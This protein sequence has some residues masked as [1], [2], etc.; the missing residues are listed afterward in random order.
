MALLFQLLFK[1]KRISFRTAKSATKISDKSITPKWLFPDIRKGRAQSYR[2][3]HYPNRGP[4]FLAFVL[5]WT[6]RNAVSGKVQ[7]QSAGKYDAYP[8]ADRLTQNPCWGKG[9][10]EFLKRSVNHCSVELFILPPTDF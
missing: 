3:L 6:G 10:V 7:G 8:V 9:L 4:N 2:D 5:A 1:I